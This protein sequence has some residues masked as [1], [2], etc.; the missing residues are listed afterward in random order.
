MVGRRSPAD[1][2]RRR[3]E[4]SQGC[5]RPRAPHGVGAA[6]LF[7]GIYR[8]FAADGTVEMSEPHP[9]QL[10]RAGGR[11]DT[12][13][14]PRQKSGS[15]LMM[16]AQQSMQASTTCLSTIQDSALLG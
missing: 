15:V 13:D 10:L 9:A 7:S 12:D 1:L 14:L 5:L 16:E 3:E 8:N 6:Q 11:T 4:Q 2:I